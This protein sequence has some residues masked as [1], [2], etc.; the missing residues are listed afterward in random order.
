MNIYI[1][2]DNERR[3]RAYDGSM[4]GLINRLLEDHFKREE[5]V[6]H[7]PFTAKKGLPCCSKRSPCKHWQWNDMKQLY[8]NSISGEEREPQL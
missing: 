1:S 6:V 8:V 4:S 3:L 2:P 7:I 5:N